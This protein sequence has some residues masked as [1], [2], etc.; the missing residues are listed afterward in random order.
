ML[1]LQHDENF[2]Q[3]EDDL[4]TQLVVNALMSQPLILTQLK[5]YAHIFI[6]SWFYFILQYIVAP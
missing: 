6:S 3:D 1:L 2:Q 5:F 4:M